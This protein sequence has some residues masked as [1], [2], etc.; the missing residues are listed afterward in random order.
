MICYLCSRRNPDV[1]ICL[2][3]L[4]IVD[5]VLKRLEST[6]SAYDSTMKSHCHH[7]WL[8]SP[9]FFYENIESIFEIGA[10]MGSCRKAGCN[11]EFLRG[12]IKSEGEKRG[13][14]SLYSPCRCC[15]WYRVL[16]E[17]V[18]MA[19]RCWVRVKRRNMGGLRRLQR[20]SQYIS[21][22][23]A[24]NVDSHESLS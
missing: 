15:P 9:A 6:R 14:S 5:K 23:L 21:V 11:A 18:A 20:Y 2:P 12:Q 3:C 17:A 22:P 4:D 16:R 13:P 7:L 19:C 24:K 10:E 1:F 8:T